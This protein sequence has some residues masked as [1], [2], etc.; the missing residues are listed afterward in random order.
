MKG[1]SA[2]FALS[3]HTAEPVVFLTV[4]CHSAVHILHHMQMANKLLYRSKQRGFLE[5]DLLVGDALEMQV[6]CAWQPM[7]D[8]QILF[9]LMPRWAY[10]LSVR[11][12][13]WTCRC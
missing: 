1:V 6:F 3:I 7:C 13:A 9:E 2:C 11:S 12:L 4:A 8:A 5:L 10:G